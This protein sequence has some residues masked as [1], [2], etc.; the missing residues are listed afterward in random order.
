MRALIATAAPGTRRAAFFANDSSHAVIS[1]DPVKSSRTMM[2]KGFPSLRENF[3][4]T[5]ETSP[6][7][8]NV[9]CSEDLSV[10]AMVWYFPE[11]KW[12]A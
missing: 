8:L 5:P 7:S 2:P 4:S 12:P 3:F 1:R 9:P 10:S 6:A 11:S